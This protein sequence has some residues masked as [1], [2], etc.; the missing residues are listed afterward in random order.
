MSL[1]L[2][3]VTDGTREHE[4]GALNSRAA[5]GG[6]ARDREDGPLRW[7][8]PKYKRKQGSRVS[9]VGRLTGKRMFC[10]SDWSRALESG[11]KSRGVLVEFPLAPVP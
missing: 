2:P 1:P 9:Q 6:A 7:N 3:F 5:R 11:R 10:L 8:W 4:D